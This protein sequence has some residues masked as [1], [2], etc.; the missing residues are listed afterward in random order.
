MGFV[1]AMGLFLHWLD[2]DV[3]GFDL[4]FG[5]WDLGIWALVLYIP[6]LVFRDLTS[7]VT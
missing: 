5:C 7:W 1:G 6:R 4:H 3:L 2:F